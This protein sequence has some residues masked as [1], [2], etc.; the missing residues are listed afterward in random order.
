[1]TK[2]LPTPHRE[3]QVRAD[4]GQDEHRTRDN[5]RDRDRRFHI[6]FFERSYMRWLSSQAAAERGSCG[7]AD[8]RAAA[9]RGTR[10]QGVGGSVHRQR[11]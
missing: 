2:N 11:R 10:S 4:G 7:H 8:S 3:A 9:R 5:Y 6:G 1:M